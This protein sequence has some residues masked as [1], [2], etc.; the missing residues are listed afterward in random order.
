MVWSIT[1]GYPVSGRFILRM[2]PQP[3]NERRFQR[4]L[5][6]IARGKQK[7]RPVSRTPF[8]TSTV[9][10]LLVHAAHA[11]RAAWTTAGRSRLLLVFLDLCD[12]RFRR[13]HQAGN[14][15]RVLQRET[16]NLGWVD[17]AHLH[18]VAIL[19]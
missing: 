11:A 8:F 18:H 6:G 10:V 19:A 13:E 15:S 1:R 2:Q 16:G 14:R 4:A 17:Y 12:E 7:G 3:V 5:G 9:A